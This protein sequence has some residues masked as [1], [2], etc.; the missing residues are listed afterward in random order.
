MTTTVS[1]RVRQ[2]VLGL[3]EKRARVGLNDQGVPRPDSEQQTE[4][5][6]QQFHNLTMLAMHDGIFRGKQT[7]LAGIDAA[8]IRIAASANPGLR[9]H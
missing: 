9:S 6:A 4:R 3:T 5:F 8:S 7:M 1:F 2:L